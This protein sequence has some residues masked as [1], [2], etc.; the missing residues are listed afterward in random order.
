[1]NWDNPIDRLKL[2]EQVGIDAY[3]IE[4]LRYIEQNPIRPVATRFGILYT[5]G[6]TGRAFS[7]RQQAEEF[8]KEKI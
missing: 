1:M 7:T 6:N 2:I 8:R 4:L 3:N 5:V